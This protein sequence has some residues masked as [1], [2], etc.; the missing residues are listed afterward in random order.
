[1][2]T[3][4]T[5]TIHLH[6]GYC[7]QPV[8]VYIRG[9]INGHIKVYCQYYPTATGWGRYPIYIHLSPKYS[10]VGCSEFASKPQIQT[11]EASSL[12]TYFAKETEYFK[13]SWFALLGA[14]L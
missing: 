7:P 14:G 13:A 5:R 10:I 8:T 9:H 4:T 6:F 1:M 3:Y 2:L 11:A 12:S